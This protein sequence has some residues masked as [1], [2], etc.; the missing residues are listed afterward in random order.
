[1]VYRPVKCA[2]KGEEQHGHLDSTLSVK[3]LVIWK[4]NIYLSICLKSTS[5]QDLTE[6][7]S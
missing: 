1:M 6:T 4:E 2:K 5:F 7:M 3:H